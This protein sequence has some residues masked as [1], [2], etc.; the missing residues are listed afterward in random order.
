MFWGYTKYNE[1]DNFYMFVFF[2][3]DFTFPKKILN[4][5][6]TL[7]EC[8][9]LQKYIALHSDVNYSHFEHFDIFRA[10]TAFP[11]WPPPGFHVNAV[12][13]TEYWISLFHLSFALCLSCSPLNT[14]AHTY[15]TKWHTYLDLET[16]FWLVLGLS[17]FQ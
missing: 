2:K 4:V 16:V 12:Y 6:L 9:N 17:L 11:H 14:H 15:T 10:G 5:F 3:S 1:V 8:T 7:L 13:V